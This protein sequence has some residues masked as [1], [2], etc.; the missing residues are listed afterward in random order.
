MR[1][2]VQRVSSARVRVGDRVTGEI[3]A[4][5][6]VLVGVS[7]DDTAADVAYV[8]AKIRDIRI[9]EGDAG[10]LMKSVRSTRSS[11]S[12]APYTRWKQSVSIGSSRRR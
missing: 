6:L 7:K 8:A 12:S 2:V 4:G 10:K 3:A 9:F 1:A 5:V 11:I